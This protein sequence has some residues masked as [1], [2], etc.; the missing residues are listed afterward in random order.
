MSEKG[1][2]SVKID[3]SLK[4]KL[5]ADLTDQGFILS[6]PVYTVFLAKKP[7]LSCTLYKSG[8]FLVQG[9]E[10]DEFIEF[11]LEPE[12]L[13]SFSY[14]HQEALLDLT[15]RIGIDEAGKGDFFGPLCI[16]G[17]FAE[18]TGV[19]NLL[20]MGVKDSKKMTD[21]SIQKMAKKIKD[22]YQH[23]VIKL[24]PRK[25]NE[26]YGK[27]KNLNYLLAWGHATAILDL[28]EKTQCKKAIID[29][30]ASKDVVETAV[31]RKKLEINLEQRH[32]GEEDLVVAAASILARD[33]FLQGLEQLGKEV[34]M[35]LPKGASSLVKEAAK[36]L[37]HHHGKEILPS[38]AKMH[39]KT[40][41]EVLKDL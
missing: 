25:Y 32:R 29:Q 10:K 30:F 26:L 1:S 27:F 36:K 39:F 21:A 23:S 13:H 28:V 34:D 16:A 3:L 5:I 4:D 31:K 11:Y 35:E 19:Q 20:K 33:A 18:G 24:F 9:K 38:V 2:F 14:K 12:I 22:S 8:V 17:V 7:R 15:G 40:S 41:G 37:I 6:H